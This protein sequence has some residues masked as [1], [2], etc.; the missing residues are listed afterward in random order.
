MTDDVKASLWGV[1]MA[2]G[3]ASFIPAAIMIG[4]Y[5]ELWCARIDVKIA[6]LHADAG[7]PEGKP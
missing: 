4:K 3:I 7:C 1:V 6:A 2:I 5:L